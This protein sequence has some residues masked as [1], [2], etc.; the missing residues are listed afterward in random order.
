MVVLPP[1]P[2]VPPAADPDPDPPPALG[3]S[4]A[5]PEPD[6]PPLEPSPF[7]LA[8]AAAS[9]ASDASFPPHARN[10]RQATEMTAA[11]LALEVMISR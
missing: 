11:T 5:E 6:P 2:V 8:A 10:E 9:S 3:L 4:E 1:V 7:A